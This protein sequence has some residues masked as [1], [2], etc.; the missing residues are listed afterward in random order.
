MTS[1]W[2]SYLRL[3]LAF[4]L[5]NMQYQSFWV[6]GGEQGRMNIE[7]NPSKWKKFRKVIFLVSFSFS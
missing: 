4:H 1:S 6:K 7:N 2:M 3:A 5:R